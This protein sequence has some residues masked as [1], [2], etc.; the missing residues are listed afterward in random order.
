MQLKPPEDI[1]LLA[2]MAHPDPGTPY[3]QLAEALDADPVGLSMLDVFRG[4]H[5][6]P[7]LFE[8][9]WQLALR[10][11]PAP[12]DL[13]V[14]WVRAW[15]QTMAH[16]FSTDPKKRPVTIE[17]PEGAM[18][19]IRARGGDA[20]VYACFERFVKTFIELSEVREKNAMRR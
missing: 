16:V 19:T 6:P 10:I 18:A 14:C 2:F 8:K 5:M 1:A 7:N 13:Q 15:E 12:R 3:V 4:Q 11:P 9:A 20:A 17:T